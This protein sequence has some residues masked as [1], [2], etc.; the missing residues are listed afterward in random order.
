MDE[1]PAARTERNELGMGRDENG[2][3][4]DLVEEEWTEGDE[5]NGDESAEEIDVVDRKWTCNGP[6][7]TVSS[8]NERET[9]GDVKIKR[10]GV[11]HYHS[12]VVIVE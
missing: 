2:R 9:D 5:T 11:R 12:K 7:G 6:R 4:M 1:R 3:R 10:K 8:N